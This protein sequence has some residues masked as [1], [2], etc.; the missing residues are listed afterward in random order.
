MQIA[1]KTNA[2]RA[3]ILFIE[4]VVDESFQKRTFSHF[5]IADKQEFEHVAR[6]QDREK[7][8]QIVTLLLK[9]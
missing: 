7:I 1:Y 9:K 5:L 8:I 4:L 6:K 2:D 3:G